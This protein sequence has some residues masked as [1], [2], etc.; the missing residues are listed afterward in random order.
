MFFIRFFEYF[1]CVRLTVN[2]WCKFL[3]SG[4]WLMQNDAEIV[5]LIESI[6]NMAIHL[7]SN[8]LVGNYNLCNKSCL[9]TGKFQSYWRINWSKKL[10]ELVFDKKSSK[11]L[12]FFIKSVW[13]YPFT[14][15]HTTSFVLLYPFSLPLLRIYFLEISDIPRLLFKVFSNETDF[16]RGN[17]STASI[18]Q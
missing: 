14:F 15:G 18:F 12:Y 3:S 16:M 4:Q 10:K 8:T 17:V 1:Y 6:L 11:V 5:V 9:V 13:K 2:Y 7:F